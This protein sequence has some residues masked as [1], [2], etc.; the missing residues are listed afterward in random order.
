MLL[1]LSKTNNDLDVY[2][3]LYALLWSICHS[4]QKLMVIWACTR[5]LACT[6]KLVTYVQIFQSASLCLT[7]TTPEQ[8]ASALWWFMIPLKLIGVP[9]PEIILTLLLSLRFINLVFDE[10]SIYG[11]C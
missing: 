7:T 11:D 3:K 1:F 4:F 5:T 9:V 2:E 8:L 6:L 10:A